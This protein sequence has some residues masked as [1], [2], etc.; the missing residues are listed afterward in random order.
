VALQFR[1]G[2]LS[3]R[4]IGS[5][6]H[7]PFGSCPDGQDLKATVPFTS[8]NVREGMPSIR[9]EARISL[10]VMVSSALPD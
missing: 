4:G 1:L 9:L 8:G 5:A 10:L 2:I 7:H 3:D 6:F